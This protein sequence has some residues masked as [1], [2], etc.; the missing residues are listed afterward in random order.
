MP[1]ARI[2]IC[3]R[4]VQHSRSVFSQGGRPASSSRRT[5]TWP[6][7]RASL[8]RTPF[9][10]GRCGRMQQWPAHLWGSVTPADGPLRASIGARGRSRPPPSTALGGSATRA[11]PPALAGA[12]SS[13]WG[14]GAGEERAL[15]RPWGWV[16][17]GGPLSRSRR[18]PLAHRRDLLQV[19]MPAASCTAFGSGEPGVAGLRPRFSTNADAQAARGV[20][21]PRRPDA[22][23]AVPL[24]G[25]QDSAYH[26]AYRRQL[27]PSSQRGPRHPPQRRVRGEAHVT[28]ISSGW[29]GPARAPRP[30][31]R[32]LVGCRV[33]F[34][35]WFGFS[36]G[37]SFSLG[38]GWLGQA[39]HG[40]RGG[41]RAPPRREPGVSTSALGPWLGVGWGERR[42]RSPRGS[43]A[44]R[45]GEA[46]ASHA[47]RAAGGW[48]SAPVR[49][50]PRPAARTGDEMPRRRSIDGFAIRR[51][52]QRS[53][54]ERGWVWLDWPLACWLV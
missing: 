11:A 4:P 38:W 29:W 27:R 48:G 35:P 6:I 19:W 25:S 21:T 28:H 8:S 7:Q 3:S 16:A 51:S 44:P 53:H 32:W 20:R 18:A 2:C 24:C 26:Q 49:P 22:F 9:G 50:S 34:Q 31:A 54:T 45:P 15:P 33:W 13:L 1:R 52:I 47:Q 40:P 42:P 39:T 41:G 12:R 5:R 43:R 37:L 36:L 14:R 23:K 10:V 46:A 30:S 17:W